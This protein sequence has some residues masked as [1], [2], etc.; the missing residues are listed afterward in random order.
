MVFSST[1]LR[2]VNTQSYKEASLLQ[3]VTVLTSADPGSSAISE[4]FLSGS[5]HTTSG[6]GQN[7]QEGNAPRWT[8][9]STSEIGCGEQGD[10]LRDK[11]NTKKKDV[12]INLEKSH[13]ECCLKVPFGSQREAV[14]SNVRKWKLSTYAYVEMY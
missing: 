14:V 13:T 12:E 3:A 11:S 1:C 2:S 6:K 10:I 9:P 8:S 4:I 5:L 7:T